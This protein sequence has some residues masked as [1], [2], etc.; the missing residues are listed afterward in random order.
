[1]RTLE[2]LLLENTYAQLPDAFHR[3]VSPT[4]FTEPAYLVSFN[5]D[6]ARLIDLLDL[7]A[8]L[9]SLR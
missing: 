4:P 8:Y 7:V 6:A 5:E 9:R 3:H 2:N 1:M